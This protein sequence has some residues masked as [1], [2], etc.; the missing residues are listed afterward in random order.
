M[1]LK[2]LGISRNEQKK[3][4]EKYKCQYLIDQDIIKKHLQYI[5][6]NF[7]LSVDG[8]N[9]YLPTIYWLLKLKKKQKM[10]SL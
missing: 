9:K 4:R 1:L 10:L 8:S 5:K 7:N 2:E 3:C 6:I